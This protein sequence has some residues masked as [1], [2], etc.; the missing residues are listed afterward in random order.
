LDSL[1][2]RYRQTYDNGLW[3]LSIFGGCVVDYDDLVDD[4]DR[5]WAEPLALVTGL[6]ADGLIRS[7]SLRVENV[8]LSVG[9][10][11]TGAAT[12]TVLAAVHALRGKFVPPSH[13]ALRS[14]NAMRQRHPERFAPAHS[15]SGSRI[16]AAMANSHSAG[17]D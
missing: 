11:Q 9:S 8:S 16:P 17:D 4:T 15:W 3:L 13:Q 2:E 10:T 5:S 7:R 12:E 1:R 6:P 14:W